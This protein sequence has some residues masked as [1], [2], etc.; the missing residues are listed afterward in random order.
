MTKR[1]NKISTEIETPTNIY[2]HDKKRP[3]LESSED[4][5][6]VAVISS[7][8]NCPKPR[9]INVSLVQN[10]LKVVIKQPYWEAFTA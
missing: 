2:L 3:F 1:Q 5:N 10:F 7:E 6:P 4:A 8:R 9:P